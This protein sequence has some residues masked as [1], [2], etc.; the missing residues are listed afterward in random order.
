M[1]VESTE[2]YFIKCTIKY[3]MVFCLLLLSGCMGQIT[4]PEDH[5]Y[6]LPD[7][8]PH[9]N[10]AEPV[11]EGAIGVEMFRLNGIPNSRSVLYVD[12]SHPNELMHYH[13]RHWVDSPEKLI[14]SSI[15]SFL[16]ASGFARNVGRTDEKILQEII[17]RGKI[18]NFERVME[19]SGPKVDVK[20]EMSIDSKQDKQPGKMKIYQSIIA[21][22][23]SSMDATIV[24]FGKA[25]KS[26][27]QVLW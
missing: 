7:I 18:I 13:Y 5:Y 23:N 16:R 8:S 14:N 11:L 17:I 4:I 10:L 6:R 19:S 3:C 25:L 12:P 24:A 26:I 2:L 21:A 9:E 1:K 27:Y 15:I 22:D 20:L